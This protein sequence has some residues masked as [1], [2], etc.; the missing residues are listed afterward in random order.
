LTGALGSW[1]ET[2]WVQCFRDLA[3]GRTAIIILHRLIAA[4]KTDITHV[5]DSGRIIESG[6]P[7]RAP[8]LRRPLCRRLAPL[9]GRPS[10]QY[11]RRTPAGVPALQIASNPCTSDLTV[12]TGVSINF[13]ACFLPALSNT[14][15]LIVEEGVPAR[16]LD[17]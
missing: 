15:D 2:D 6:Q 1:A 17:Q 13:R 4:M 3:L 10:S 11:T 12:E 5:M 9:D 8:R 14:P 16:R 7:R